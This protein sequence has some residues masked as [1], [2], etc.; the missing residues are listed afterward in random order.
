[1]VE[2]L[3]LIAVG[4]LGGLAENPEGQT[5]MTDGYVVSALGTIVLI[6]VV[7]ARRSP[8]VLAVATA[9]A[10]AL[11]FLVDNALWIFAAIFLFAA[12]ALGFVSN[13]DLRST[14]RNT[15]RWTR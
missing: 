2:G 15:N 10:A 5:A 7:L 6:A 9:A 3:L 12:A 13:R 14:N 1:M 11:G 4:S 8:L